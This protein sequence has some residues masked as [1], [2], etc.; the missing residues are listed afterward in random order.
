MTDHIKPS[1]STDP[2]TSSSVSNKFDLNQYLICSN[3]PLSESNSIANINFQKDNESLIYPLVSSSLSNNNNGNKFLKYSSKVPIKSQDIKNYDDQL[4]ENFLNP[5]PNFTTTNTNISNNTYLVKDFDKAEYLSSNSSSNSQIGTATIG[6]SNSNSGSIGVDISHTTATAAATTTTTI[7]TI[8]EGSSSCKFQVSPI[9][10]EDFEREL[11][12]NDD[13]DQF[14]NGN[15]EPT[16]ICWS[17]DKIHFLNP[18]LIQDDDVEEEEQ[19]HEQ[20][21]ANQIENDEGYE[22]EQENNNDNSDYNYR[23]IAF[24]S[25]PPPAQF[26]SSQ[27]Q[28]LLNLQKTSSDTLTANESESSAIIDGCTTAIAIAIKA[29]QLLSQ[30]LTY[31]NNNNTSSN[32]FLEYLKSDEELEHMSEMKE[33]LGLKPAFVYKKKTTTKDENICG[34][35]QTSTKNEYHDLPSSPIVLVKKPNE[36]VKDDQ[37]NFE[38]KDDTYKTSSIP[39]EE[40]RKFK[41]RFKKSGGLRKNALMIHP[42]T[43]RFNEHKEEFSQH[44]E[45]IN[46]LEQKQQKVERQQQAAERRSR[47]KELSCTISSKPTTNPNGA[48]EIYEIGPKILPEPFSK[49]FHNLRKKKFLPLL[50]LMEDPEYQLGYGQSTNYNLKTKNTTRCPNRP[51]SQGN[52]GPYR[53]QNSKPKQ[54]LST[55]NGISSSSSS[56]SSTSS[57]T[58]TSAS[59]SASSSSSSTSSSTTRSKELSEK[60]KQ[61]TSTKQESN[62]V[63]SSSS[64]ETEFKNDRYYSRLNIYELSKILNLHQYSIQLTKLIE[65]NILEIFGNYCDFQLGYQTWIRDTTKIKRKELIQQL[66]SYTVEFYPEIDPFKLEVI[67]RR[68]SYSLMQTRLRR[69]RRLKQR[70]RD[71]N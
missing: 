8:T 23:F 54:N 66:Y 41:R 46:A 45:Q 3:N 43:I 50:V 64:K 33:K 67:I 7:A 20:E 35:S 1:T 70:S 65:L 58:S 18:N 61:Q 36:N 38:D 63:G 42:F 17:S 60:K 31:N 48:T 51:N 27:Q 53:V 68:G 71:F 30:L 49:E 13:D 44:M 26:L 4:D 28:Q 25:S 57:S 10:F 14:S 15:G 16:L 19:Q 62:K 34:P 5:S 2:P 52:L 24:G 29:K 39:L 55:T 32:I 56:S 11:N 12:N 47:R 37:D 6:K 59:A 9:E 40:D 21:I 22:Y 69:E